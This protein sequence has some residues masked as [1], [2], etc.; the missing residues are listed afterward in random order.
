MLNERYGDLLDNVINKKDTTMID[1]V[2]RLTNKM[3]TERQAEVDRINSNIHNKELKKQSECE[4]IEN[5]NAI[6]NKWVDVVKDKHEL[7]VKLTDAKQKAIHDAEMRRK[8]N[9]N[10]NWKPSLIKR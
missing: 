4:R 9:E 3:I 8:T 6:L 2:E 7:E 1:T 5:S 10:L